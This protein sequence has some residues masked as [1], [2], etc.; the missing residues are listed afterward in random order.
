V[1]PR[2]LKWVEAAAGGRLVQGLPETV[3]RGV[4]TDSRRVQPGDLFIALVGERHDA[5]RFLEQVAAAGATAVLVNAQCLTEL[6]LPNV[7]IVAVDDTRA[8]LGRMAGVYRLEFDPLVIAVGGSNGK[9]T[10]K[11]LIASVLRRRF[12]TLASEASFNNDIGVPLTLLKLARE[13]QAAVVEVG[14]NHPG[15]LA[16]LVR[17]ARPKFGVITSIGHEHLEFFG[18]V[19]GVAAEEGW[20]PELLPADGVFFVNGDSEWTE[21]LVRRTRARVVRCGFGE[22][23]DWKASAVRLDKQ[24]TRFEV[25]APGMNCSGAYR[26]PLLGRHQAGN[27][28]LA[29]AIG[30]ECFQHLTSDKTMQ[31][32]MLA[33]L[34]EC[35]I[36]RMRAQIVELNGITVL[37]DAYNANLDSMFAALETIGELP[38]PGRRIAVL[39]DMAE[40]GDTSRR[41]HEQVGQFAAASRIDHLFAVGRMSG[42]M[43]A[44]A[45][46]AGLPDVKLFVS[47]EDAAEALK[48]FVAA[49]DLLLLKASRTMG[50]ERVVDSL[51]QAA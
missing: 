30:S 28:L 31:T 42:F 46:K 48:K 25:Q 21:Q 24:G 1:E 8:A 40:L 51:Q 7:A 2:S 17:I 15:E 26:L 35:P 4:S 3:V 27:A 38:C 45:R 32:E 34:E 13:H 39:G 16:P 6:N 10:T 9:T 49:G 12:T 5:H 47:V 18:D 14:T 20:L 29:L 44:A 37:N 41:A 19:A 23:N 36:P 11:E 43:A 50:M 22:S 33:G